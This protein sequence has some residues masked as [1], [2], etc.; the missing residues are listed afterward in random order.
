MRRNRCRLPLPHK[1]TY[2]I[3]P[4]GRHPSVAPGRR[5]GAFGHKSQLQV[6]D[7]PV[8]DAGDEMEDARPI[9]AALG[10]QEM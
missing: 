1:I 3:Q 6:L 4:A 10:H 5:R 9:H 8:V 7:D 2:S